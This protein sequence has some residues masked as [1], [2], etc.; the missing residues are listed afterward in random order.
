MGTGQKVQ[1]EEEEEEGG[2]GGEGEKKKSSSVGIAT[3]CGLH[4][5]GIGVRVPVG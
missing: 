4:N 1:E 2:G 5:G 3:D